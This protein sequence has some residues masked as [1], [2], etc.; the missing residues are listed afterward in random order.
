VLHVVETDQNVPLVPTKDPTVAELEIIY[1]LSCNKLTVDECVL[2]QA[3]RPYN[4]H[5]SRK[6]YC[7]INKKKTKCLGRLN[8]KFNKGKK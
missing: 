6:K 3:N 1:K 5:K 7:K 8:G 2:L 4:K